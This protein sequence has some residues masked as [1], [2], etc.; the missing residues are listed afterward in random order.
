VKV[1]DFGLAKAFA[2]GD[3]NANV[4]NSPTLTMGATEQGIILGTAAYMSP[5]QALGKS[6]DRRT[7]VWALGA[8]IYEMLT[9]KQA[10]RR[11]NVG[12]IPATVVKTVP[13]WS[14]LPANTPESIRTLLRRCLRKDRRQR[15]GDVGDARIELE[16][17][18]VSPAAVAVDSNNDRRKS[19]SLTAAILVAFV[20]IAAAFAIGTRFSKPPVQQERPTVARLNLSLPPGTEFSD[21]QAPMVISPD[22]TQGA[23]QRL[24]EAGASEEQI[25]WVIQ[26]SIQ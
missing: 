10:F 13:D 20:A 4:S 9:G 14:L 21:V 16:E 26:Q 2:A 25:E 24:R 15:L 7:D 1:L 17:A 3:G 8:V 22:G 18:L 12:D 5:E 19:V 6:L 11:E 23:V